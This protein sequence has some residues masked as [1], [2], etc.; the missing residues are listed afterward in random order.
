[1]KKSELKE[2]IKNL[3]EELCA[4]GKAYRKKRMAAGEKSSAY[5]SG[6]AVKVCKGQ[7]KGE[8]EDA[9]MKKSALGMAM[10]GKKAKMNE[11]EG[12][13][14][15]FG[16]QTKHFD[17]CPGAQSLYKAIADGEHG[18][19][20]KDLVI[21][22]AKA[23][24]TLFYLEKMAIEEKIEVTPELVDIAQNQADL[25]MSAA[26]EKMDLEKE[27]NYVQGH[28]DKIKGLMKEGIEE[29][30]EAKDNTEFKITLKH[31]L[32]KH[33]SKGGEEIDEVNMSIDE[34]LTLEIDENITEAKF[35][36]KTVKLNS[37]MRGDSKK[38]KVYV[39]N[40]KNK[41]G[42]IKVKKVNF[43]HGG[44]SAKKRGEKTLKIRKSNPKARAAFRARHRCD[45]P[46][47]KTMARYWSCKKW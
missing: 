25:I 2:I 4:K 1:M 5:L 40:G 6:R 7:I 34:V 22:V 3:V 37:P 46:G 9:A 28:V 15:I 8:A 38:F 13:V 24:D 12:E 29:D 30:I 18:K 10:Y 19:Q 41:D 33:V 21:R 16:Y 35:K 44:T 32:D 27:H 45:N 31:L 20:D 43:G 23:H 47:P 17:V 36:G 26:K 14:N 11:A 42:S 39:A